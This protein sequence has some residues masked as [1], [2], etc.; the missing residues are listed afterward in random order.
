MPDYPTL[1]RVEELER[2]YGHPKGL[3]VTKEIP[4]LNEHY[5]AFIET[6]PFVVLATAGPGGLDCSP[7]GDTPGFVRILDERT[8][9]IPD[10]PG[11][12]R[13][14]GLRN[15]VDDPRVALLFIVPGAG[16]TL[17]VNGRATVTDDADLLASFAVNG[18]LPRTV[19]LVVVDAAYIHCSKAIMRSKLWDPTRHVERTRLPSLGEMGDLAEQGAGRQRGLRSRHGR[20]PHGDAVLSRR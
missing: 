13:I 12:N 5:R 17:R 3:A 4:F 20:T 2:I 16:E 7:K 14:D 18:K 8:L 15:V 19:I 10:R 1:S 11:N 9:A 6:A